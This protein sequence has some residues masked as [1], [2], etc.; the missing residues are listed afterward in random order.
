MWHQHIFVGPL[1]ASWPAELRFQRTRW[2]FGI[3]QSS[4]DEWDDASSDL[5]AEVGVKNQNLLGTTMAMVYS[6]Y[7]LVYLNTIERTMAS[8][9]NIEFS[10]IQWIGFEQLA[11]NTC[12]FRWLLNWEIA[13]KITNFHHPTYSVKRITGAGWQLGGRSS[14]KSQEIPILLMLRTTVFLW[15]SPK[16]TGSLCWRPHSTWKP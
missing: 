3:K 11:G 5:R 7:R 16:T 13:S 1:C 4:W 8:W 15:I 9:T 6:G 12:F 14:D 10:R 2:L